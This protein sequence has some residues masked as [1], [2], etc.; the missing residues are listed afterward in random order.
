M[1]PQSSRAFLAE[2]A[3]TE[4]ETRSFEPIAAFR[5]EIA[6]IKQVEH[7]R[8]C[9]WLILFFEPMGWPGAV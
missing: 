7:C 1:L 9:G 8:N 4:F 6:L 2:M 5:A 3:R